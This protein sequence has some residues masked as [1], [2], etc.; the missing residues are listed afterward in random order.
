LTAEN[1]PI[2]DEFLKRLDAKFGTSSI[3]N[4]KLPEA[5]LAKAKRPTTLAKKPW[6]DVEHV[7]D[8][9]RF[10]TVL[11]DITRLPDIIE[12]MEQELRP[13]VLKRD[14]DKFLQPKAFGWRIC[15]FDL[16]MPNGQIIEYYLLVEE[17]NELSDENHKLFK[18]WRDRNPSS[19]SPRE[20][21]EFLRDADT[22]YFS[23]QDAFERYL[24]RS[25]NSESDVRAA[26]SKASASST[27]TRENSSF[28][29]SNEN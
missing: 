5:I 13:K 7:R 17:M 22:S 23:F 19:L 27:G 21:E 29:S 20:Y 10:K 11:Q 12:Y 8:S 2:V 16:Q 25:G 24:S 26:L 6:H 15:V 1:K 4:E 3:S 9:F 28:T 18:K 14:T